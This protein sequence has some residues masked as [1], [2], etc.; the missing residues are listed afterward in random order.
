M[1]KD[2]EC[3]YNLTASILR[4]AASD[5]KTAIRRL[6]KNPK[7]AEGIRVKNEV[8]RFV[9]SEWFTALCPAE[10]SDVLSHWTRE[11]RSTGR[12]QK[13]VAHRKRRA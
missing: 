13:F 6:D 8:E 9:H 3:Y 12:N 10:P 5:Y 7:H 11:A 1:T 4:M 2:I